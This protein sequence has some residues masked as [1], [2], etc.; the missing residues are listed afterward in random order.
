VRIMKYRGQYS[1]PAREGDV[2]RGMS[3][4]AGCLRLYWVLAVCALLLSG[5]L[6][7][8]ERASLRVPA[9]TGSEPAADLSALPLEIGAWIGED[10]PL[11]ED[12]VRAAKMDDSLS[13]LYVN[14]SAN[15]WANIYAAL[16]KRPA[17]MVGHRP[18]V[19]YV[20]AGWVLEGTKEGRFR[21]TSG[22]DLP[23]RLH[24]FRRMQPY[25]ERLVVLNYYILNGKVVCTEDEFSGVEW[26]GAAGA[27][28]VAQV[29]ISSTLENSARAFAEGVTE[30]IL[31]LLS[32]EEAPTTDRQYSSLRVDVGSGRSETQ[33]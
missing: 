21:S 11:R 9:R 10:A 18:E 19:C 13:R 15:Q 24:T 14:K 16:S 32:G 25:D 4:D 26:R 17:A 5:V 12:V 1:G 28:Y 3:P 27:H 20:A 23:C 2:V 7:R 33:R 22:T 30:S 8:A 29:Q 31:K 6:Y